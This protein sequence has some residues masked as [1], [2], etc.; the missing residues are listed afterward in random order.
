MKIIRQLLLGLRN[1]RHKRDNENEY[2]QTNCLYYINSYK[3]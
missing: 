2:T 3:K 1:E